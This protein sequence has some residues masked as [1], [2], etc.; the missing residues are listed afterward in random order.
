MPETADIATV[1][2]TR[3]RCR[4]V[5]ADGRQCGSPA[6]RR[7]SFCYFHHSTR[8]P[9]ANPG[10]FRYLDATE[11]FEL[12]IVE[13]IPSALSVAAQIL[14]RIASN[15]L[16]TNRA[17]KMLYNLQIITTLLAR[18]ARTE[19]ASE[20]AQPTLQPVLVEE[21]VPDDNHGPLAPI[22]ELPPNH[23]IAREPQHDE[24]VPHPTPSPVIVSEERSDESKDPDALSTTSTARTVPPQQPATDNLQPTTPN[25]EPTQNPVI[26]SP[27]EGNPEGIDLTP[28]A[29]HL[30]F[31]PNPS[32]WPRSTP[33]PP[34]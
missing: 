4:H 28:T 13:D 1:T 33:P 20:P 11:P 17:G 8:R 10:K 32:P 23:T 24:P 16:D 18:A 19:P 34:N 25:P 12:P 6:L 29:D 26:L 15:D 14:C 5:H 3:F 7:E 21:L 31:H 30:F 27:A 9:K 2:H 22:T